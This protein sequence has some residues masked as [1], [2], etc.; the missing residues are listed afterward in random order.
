DVE[1]VI[2]E[3]LHAVDE[4]DRMRHARVTLERRFVVPT[5]MDVEELGVAN[6]SKRVDAEAPG[7]LPRRSHD[8]TQRLGDGRLV[9]GPR[10]KSGKDEER[11]VPIVPDHRSVDIVIHYIGLYVHYAG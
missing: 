10:M 2:D 8:V 3:R 1:R 5:R 6:R 11:H 9:A 4:A 7:L